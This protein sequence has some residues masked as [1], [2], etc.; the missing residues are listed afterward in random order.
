MSG[1]R[2]LAATR[3]FFTGELERSPRPTEVTTDRAPASPRVLEEVM[4]A[5]RAM[6]WSSMRI[7]LSRL[8]TDG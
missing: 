1:K 2:D 8:I 5:A 4:P 6:W 3:R 7:I